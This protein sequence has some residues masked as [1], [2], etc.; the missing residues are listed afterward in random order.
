M[1]MQ[2]TPSSGTTH[3]AQALRARRPA[4]RAGTVA[5]ARTPEDAD[6]QRALA[7]LER[8]KPAKEIVFDDAVPQQSKADLA[9]FRPASY[10]R[11]RSR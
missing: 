4:A 2:N 3:N 6:A 5:A 11:T 8:G 9:K 10:R 7:W 1:T